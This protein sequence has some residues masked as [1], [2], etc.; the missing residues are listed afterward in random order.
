ISCPILGRNDRARVLIAQGHRVETFIGERGRSMDALTKSAG[1]APADVD[2]EGRAT[3]INL[4]SLGTPQMRAFHAAWLAFFLCFFAWFGVAPLMKTVRGELGL[5]KS[6]IGNIIIAS[7][8]VTIVTRLVIGWL[9]DQ[10]GPRITYAALLVI[11]S[12]PVMG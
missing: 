8:A 4:F 6:Q 5:T 1:P 12:L 3:R 11:A 7:V 9:L 2:A 10:I